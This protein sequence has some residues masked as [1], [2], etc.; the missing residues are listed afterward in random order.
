MTQTRLERLRAAYQ[1]ASD[2]TL[3]LYMD[4]REE[5]YPQQQALL[6]AGLTDPPDMEPTPYNYLETGA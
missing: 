3:Y 6:M 4:L 5:G 1:G 2:E